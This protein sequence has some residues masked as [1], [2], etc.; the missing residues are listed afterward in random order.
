M[1]MSKSKLCSFGARISMAKTVCIYLTEVLDQ[2]F[3]KTKALFF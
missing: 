2:I 1:L 3:L